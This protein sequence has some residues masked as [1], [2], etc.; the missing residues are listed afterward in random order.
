MDF[1]E[2]KQLN[3]ADYHHHQAWMD[4]AL[5][6]A[7]SAGE[8]GEIPVGAVIVDPQGQFLAEA[9]NEKVKENDPTAHA[10]L[11]AVRAAS[12]LLKNWRLEGCTLYVTLEP[13]PM[14]AG[15]I[16][17]SRL[18]RLVYGADDPK[19]GAVRS[20]LN[21]PDSAVSNHRLLVI[22]GIRERACGELLQGWFTARRGISSSLHQKAENRV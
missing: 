9:A 3:Y 1:E 5:R 11:L 20:V 22:G 8:R 15:A 6:L 10:E 19:T 21:L 16:I 14:C 13:C 7:H 2:F 4:R 18:K 12:R 17:H